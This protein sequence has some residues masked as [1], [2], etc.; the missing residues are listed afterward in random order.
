[1][2]ECPGCGKPLIYPTGCDRCEYENLESGR[3]HYCG[4]RGCYCANLPGLWS[5]HPEVRERL[6][7]DH[8]S[9]QAG[10]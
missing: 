1:M 2:T 8:R 4:E 5:M 9:R 10:V 3:Y 7:R 6:V